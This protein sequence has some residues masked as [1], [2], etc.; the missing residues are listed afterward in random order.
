MP[1]EI[2]IMFKGMGEKVVKLTPYVALLSGVVVWSYLHSIG[3]VDI[4][5][6]VL[7]FNAGLISILISTIIFALGISITLIIPSSVLIFARSSCEN[8]SRAES[9]LMKLPVACLMLSVLYL[10]MGYIPFIPEVDKWIHGYKPGV[11]KITVFVL[12]LSFIFVFLTLVRNFER[13]NESSKFKNLIVFVWFVVVNT[14]I[15]VG[16]TLSISIPVSFLMQSSKGESSLAIVFSLVFMAV[17][18]F[19]AFFPAIIY[20]TNIKKIKTTI[21]IVSVIHQL[22][23]ATVGVVL[24]TFLLFPNISTIFIYSSLNAIGMVSKTP[25]FYLVNGEKYKPAM[26]YKDAWDTRILPDM[27][28]GFYIKGVN[29]FSVEG[30]NLICPIDV[31]K[32]R[33]ETYQ[34]DYVSFIPSSDSEKITELKKR[35]MDCLILENDDIQQWDTLFDDKGNAKL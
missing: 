6:E 30:K 19:L 9:V 28:E 1:E 21:S 14:L 5:P 25:H 2:K 11:M 24:L 31:V 32:V 29:V 26:F 23:L 22:P 34:R 8:N 4:F 12:A 3:R 18:S 10:L 7:S 17:F 20:F 27:G 13:D 15:T 35:T 33:D 16:A